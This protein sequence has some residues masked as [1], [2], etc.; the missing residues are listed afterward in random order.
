MPFQTP[1]STTSGKISPRCSECMN[2][3]TRR[4]CFLPLSILSSSTSP[5]VRDGNG[6]ILVPGEDVMRKVLLCLVTSEERNRLLSNLTTGLRRVATVCEM[7]LGQTTTGRNQTQPPTIGRNISR[8]SARIVTPPRYATRSC[9]S[10]PH[11][12][13][14]QEDGEYFPAKSRFHKTAS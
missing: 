5:V 10:S 2:P 13:T 8:R 1:P 3:K 4:C 12:E 11:R 14:A 6:Y 7:S 9:A